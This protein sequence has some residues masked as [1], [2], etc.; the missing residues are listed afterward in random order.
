MAWVNAPLIFLHIY[1]SIIFQQAQ[2]AYSPWT[3]NTSNQ[4]RPAIQV[5]HRLVMVAG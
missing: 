1:V 4:N 5:N 3:L 2:N